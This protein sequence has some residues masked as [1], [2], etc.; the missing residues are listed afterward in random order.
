MIAR[1]VTATSLS[2]RSASP[3]AMMPSET[4]KQAPPMPARRSVASDV[5][6]VTRAYRDAGFAI[7]ARR[8]EDEWAALRLSLREKA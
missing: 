3:S 5:D 4:R 8:D 2:M 7:D 6:A 1:P